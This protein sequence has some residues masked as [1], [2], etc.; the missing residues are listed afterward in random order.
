MND[1][2][3]REFT[4]GAVRR[5]NEHQNPDKDSKYS[6]ETNEDKSFTLTVIN[7]A[8]GGGLNGLKILQQVTPF[9]VSKIQVR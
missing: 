2:K 4:L 7:P 6:R 3:L 8:F 1:P 5:H 9:R